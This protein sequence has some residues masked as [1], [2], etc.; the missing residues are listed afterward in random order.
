MACDVAC[1]QLSG[2]SF[3]HST[4]KEKCEKKLSPKHTIYITTSTNV[5]ITIPLG[6]AI[7]LI[8]TNIETSVER[9]LTVY[10]VLKKINVSNRSNDVTYKRIR[11]GIRTHLLHRTTLPFFL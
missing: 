11:Q 1:V 7:R 3:R 4:T 10:S 8:G 2:N 6:G 9:D 5:H